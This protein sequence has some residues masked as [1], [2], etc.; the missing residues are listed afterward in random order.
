MQY[1]CI[2]K[3]DDKKYKSEKC[4]D[5]YQTFHERNGIY[6]EKDGCSEKFKILSN[7]DDASNTFLTKR[8][9]Y[10]RLM[11]DLEIVI[12][13]AHL[14]GDKEICNH[15]KEIFVLCKL[16]LWDS[17]DNLKIIFSPWGFASDKYPL[18]IPEK[19]RFNISSLE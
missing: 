17:N 14:N 3:K 4:S 12:G 10:L 8:D 9:D 16:C 5:L 13:E 15:L 18:D 19:Y 11:S 2:R 1:I 7:V 6:L